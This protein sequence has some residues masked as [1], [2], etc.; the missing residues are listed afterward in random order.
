MF[1]RSNGQITVSE[2]YNYPNENSKFQLHSCRQIRC[3][4]L[5]VQ[6]LLFSK[7]VTS[8]FKMLR[9]L[10]D[11]DVSGGTIRGW[12][13][14]TMEKEQ[15]QG[16]RSCTFCLIL[17]ASK[18]CSLRNKTNLFFLQMLKNNTPKFCNN[19]FNKLVHLKI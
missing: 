2:E 5:S 3:L 14:R 6:R 11:N 16:H 9:N 4:G 7:T 12:L 15:V 1:V 8:C 13:L 18:N 17:L 19:K 10:G